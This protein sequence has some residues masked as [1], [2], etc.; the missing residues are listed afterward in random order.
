MDQQY[1][2][3]FGMVFVCICTVAGVGIALYN[4]MK[5]SNKEQRQPIDEL[6]Q[7]IIGLTYEIKHMRNNDAVR[8][9]RLDKHG[10]EIDEINKKVT[11]NTRRIDTLE[12]ARH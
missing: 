4:A 3:I 11:D 12:R 7:S 5:Q 6:N 9:K 10:E 8:D 2:I 1:Y